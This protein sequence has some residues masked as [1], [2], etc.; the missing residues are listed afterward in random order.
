MADS[1]MNGGS[2]DTATFGGVLI[3]RSLVRMTPSG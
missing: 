2:R 3:W 1:F